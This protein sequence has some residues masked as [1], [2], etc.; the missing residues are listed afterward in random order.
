MK[1]FR[2]LPTI[3]LAALAGCISTN[4]GWAASGDGDATRSATFDA[5]TVRGAFSAP[6]VT[7]IN[8]KLLTLTQSL[9][10]AKGVAFTSTN[11]QNYC[12]RLGITSPDAI[13]N[14]HFWFNSLRD[15]SLTTNL[16]DFAFF[17]ADSQPADY[18]LSWSNTVGVLGSPNRLPGGIEINPTLTETNSGLYVTN[19]AA[20]PNGRT[21]I[22]WFH[23]A[24]SDWGET[25]NV[26]ILGLSKDGL[27]TF[28]DGAQLASEVSWSYSLISLHDG[29]HVQKISAPINTMGETNLFCVAMGTTSN[30]TRAAFL[31]PTHRWYAS[32]STDGVATGSPSVARL[33]T[34]LWRT[35]LP[36]PHAVYRGF[37]LFNKMLSSNEVFE[38]DAALRR[39]GLIVDGDSKTAGTGSWPTWYMQSAPNWGLVQLLTN[40]GVSGIALSGAGDTMQGHWAGNARLVP[41]ATFPKV[42][43]AVRGG[44]H[45]IND[46]S[47][48]DRVS[49]LINGASNLLSNIRTAG[50]MGAIFTLEPTYVSTNNGTAI[51]QFN[52]WVR[53][54]GLST[55]LIDSEAYYT[56]LYGPSC[57]TNTTIFSDGI[58]E[59]ALGY[60]LLGTNLVASA[61]PVRLTAPPDKPAFWFT[62]TNAA[63]RVY[64]IP[65]F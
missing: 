19:I 49:Y 45:D 5:V 22:A 60:R 8:S 29:G 63:G 38:V 62:M 20:T 28:S 42:I 21:L 64:R 3:A 30:A 41:N 55:W 31:S 46:N 59:T 48:A 13:A 40:S 12:T 50:M 34:D 43:Y 44:L 61:I 27:Q 32:Q 65:A 47:A 1:P 35:N 9:S 11:A 24:Y 26:A 53:T 39:I 15:A 16:V 54:N 33:G 4:P 52:S 18:L 51:A 2:L 36:S 6:E 25:N 17:D 37:A 58:H 56:N 23:P 10:L 14:V 7:S 57:W